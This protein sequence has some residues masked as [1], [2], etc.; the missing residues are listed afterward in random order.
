MYIGL[1]IK[2]SQ[3]LK[4]VLPGIFLLSSIFVPMLCLHRV[5]VSNIDVSGMLVLKVGMSGKI[6]LGMDWG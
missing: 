5:H 1:K 3:D 2:F 4:E 6:G